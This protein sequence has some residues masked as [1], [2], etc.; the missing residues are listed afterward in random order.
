MFCKHKWE[1]INQ[2]LLLSEMELL[3]KAGYVP[4]GFV[5]RKQ[6]LI[7]DYVCSECGK[8][9]RFKVKTA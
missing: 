4:N 6:T 3:D 9:R 1:K 2:E 5:K 8:L 7:T